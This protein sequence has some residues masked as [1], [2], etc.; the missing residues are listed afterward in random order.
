MGWPY[1]AGIG[2]VDVWAAVDVW[3]GLMLLVLGLWIYGLALCCCRCMGW[4]YAAGIGP[5]DVW[6][7]IGP[8]DVWT[9]VGERAWL[10]TTQLAAYL[11]CIFPQ[12]LQPYT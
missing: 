8:V 6:A 10:V 11:F 1:A 4:P 7:G 12:Q 9:G 3:A 2:P 5:V